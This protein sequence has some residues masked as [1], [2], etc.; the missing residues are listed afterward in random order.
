MTEKNWRNS[1][2]DHFDVVVAAIE[3]KD[4]EQLVSVIKQMTKHQI[5]TVFQ[6][7]E[8]PWSSFNSGRG[9]SSDYWEPFKMAVGEVHP[10]ILLFGKNH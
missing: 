1:S 10:N 9:Y 8:D 5:T 6:E 4:H 2:L 7:L 3:S